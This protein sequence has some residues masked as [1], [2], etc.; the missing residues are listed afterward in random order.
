MLLSGG[1][2]TAQNPSIGENSKNKTL[3][4]VIV[5]TRKVEGIEHAERLMQLGEYQRAADLLEVMYEENPG[6][7]GIKNLLVNCYEQIKDYGKLLLFLT[8]RLATEPPGFS[9]YRD[10]GRAYTF[11]GIPDSAVTFFYMAAEQGFGNERAYASIAEIYH[12]FGHYQLESKFIDSSRIL[13]RNP[14]LLADRM[15]DALAAQ[16]EYGMATLEYLTYME[17]D[18]LAARIA[19]EKLE[20]MMR[21]PESA[22]TVMSILSERIKSQKENKRLLNTY[23]RLLMEQDR[24]EEAF[25]FFKGLD[26]LGAGM[27]GE[28]VHYMR[29][30]NR[31]GR[32]EYTIKGGQYLLEYKPQSTLIN[33]V[34][35][36]MAEAFTAIGKYDNALTAYQAITVDFIRPAHRAE[37]QLRIGLLYKD[38]LEDPGKAREYLDRVTK[39]VPGG[40]FDVLARL[41]LADL[42]I[43]EG[44]FDSAVSLY[45]S[46]QEREIPEE[47]LEQVEFALA[48]CYLF[49][50]DYKEATSRFRQIISRYPRGFYVNDAIQ[51]SLIISET[52]EAAPQQ[53]DLFASAEY[54]RYSDRVD[55]VEYY[56][57]KICRVGIPSLAPISYLRLAQLYQDQKRFDEAVEAVDSLVSLHPESY[58]L[59]Y[60]LKLKADVFLPSPETSEEAMELYRELLEN[61]ATYPFAA[62]IRDIIRRQTPADQ[63]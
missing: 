55:S 61:Y 42:A 21:F 46:L 63:I 39:S 34:H 54:F 28:I 25:T 2:S 12:K 44:G 40:R 4:Q 24:F 41:G 9:L 62:E 22:D 51:Y 8:R 16:R 53:I 56:L 43:R 5:K 33:S 19:T 60:G 32:F 58:F 49:M 57:T 31:R 1:V 7:L 10:L 52:L 45:Q 14:R 47:I 26:S 36:T 59:P 18:T 13:T 17:R 6:H 11:A 27:G 37:A 29:E 35:L 20:A 3:P 50:E 23:G 38:H 48:E 15:G 30:C